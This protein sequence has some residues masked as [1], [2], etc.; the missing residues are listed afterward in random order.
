MAVLI[1]GVDDV[2]PGY[3]KEVPQ[4][5]KIL[6]ETKINKIWVTSRNSLK[7]HLETALKCQ[8]YSLECFSEEH[9]KQFL[10][11]FWKETCPE[12]EYDY[13]DKMANEVVILS[14]KQLSVQNRKF[15]GIP[16]QSLLLAEM[17]EG[18]LKD[19]STQNSVGLPKD[20]DVII[21][22]KLY[23]KK[24]LDVYLQEK[25]CF[26]QTNVVARLEGAKLY[27]TFMDNHKADTLVAIMSTQNFENIGDK[28][29]EKRA[30]KFLKKITD[31]DRKPVL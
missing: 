4:F 25:I 16:L 27:K 14:V 30:R 1:D 13:L 23:V 11:R 17:F 19:Y 2:S 21:L 7:D 22:C 24:K 3:A 9:Q 28:K 10:V 20:I 31:G 18:Y 12:I 6:S 8:P 15:M 29:I 26:D 5:L